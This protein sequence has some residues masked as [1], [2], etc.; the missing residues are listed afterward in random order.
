MNNIQKGLAFAVFILFLGLIFIPSINANISKERMIKVPVTEFKEDGTK[1]TTIIKMSLSDLMFLK[2]KL[3]D[4]K[5]SEEILSLYKEYGLIPKDASRE[6]MREGMLRLAERFNLSEEKLSF[7]VKSRKPVGDFAY[8]FGVDFY[9]EVFT[10]GIPD[11][12]L[13]VGLSFI[14]GPLNFIL[15]DLLYDVDID[16]YFWLPS[17][18]LVQFHFFPFIGFLQTWNE[19]DQV[20]DLRGM[21]LFCA[22]IGF[23][24]FSFQFPIISPVGVTYGY[25]IASI[26]LGNKYQHS[27]K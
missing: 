2:E 3:Q 19:T 18:D 25:S 24:G 27:S 7:L 11:I 23:V 21:L 8:G 22:I 5:D 10:L 1:E 12:N 16:I 9:C 20:L 4:A 6:K 15:G 26:G 17:F 14:T 13:P